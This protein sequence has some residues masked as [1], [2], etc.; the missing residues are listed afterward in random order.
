[1]TKARGRK[2]AT[3]VSAAQAARQALVAKEFAAA[4]LGDKRRE[5]RVRSIAAAVAAKPATPFPRALATEGDL[6]GFYR[7]V[8]NEAVSFDDLLTPHV[9]AT[10]GRMTGGGEVLA[11]HD[12]TQFAFGGTRRGLG[13][14]NQSGHGFLSQF[15][16][17]VSAE[18][19]R[20]PL[21]VLAVESWV[22]QEP[23]KTALL[24]QRKVTYADSYELPNEQDRWLR[25]VDA[26]EAVVAGA[27]SLIHVMDSEADDYELMAKL[28]A[29]RRRW[30]IRLCYDRV[31]ANTEPGAPHKTKELV[32]SRKVRCRRTVHLSRRR[33]QPG[34]DKR[35]RTRVRK[36]R[37]AILAISA[38]P[39][40]F[41][42]PSYCTDSATTLSVNIVAVREVNP[43]PDDEPVAW[44]LLST[45]P[46][47]TEEQILTVV[48]SYRGRWVIEEYF[49]AIK[50]GCAYEKRQLESWHTL[51]NAL[52]VIIPIAWSLL[53]LRTVARVE[54]SAPART[55]LT[56]LEE[57][58]LRAAVTTPLPRAA[59]ARD[60]M[61]AIARLG[62]HLRSNGEPG[63]QVLGR[64]YQ[65]L[66]MM[67]AGY[68]LAQAEK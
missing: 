2:A 31:L 53:H 39:V 47:D 65:D 22:R 16:L 18:G 19:A 56:E 67:T 26:A 6:E 52:G 23:T 29:A 59:T 49:K 44:L 11:V 66:L 37:D 1:M 12:T 7:L 64:G 13:R 10:V 14:L 15:T 63:W 46:I 3:V 32:A 33:R 38:T 45:E 42:R 62:G 20:T 28:V 51:L 21:G 5:R 57:K 36:E 25:G 61:L 68:R 54:G 35:S 58:V 60:V 24:K 48:D 27:V 50:T 55:V 41:R 8:R 34:G 9:A 4:D 17:A 30:I 40:V 43:P